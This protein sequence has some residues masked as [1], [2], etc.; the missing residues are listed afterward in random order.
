M[1]SSEQLPYFPF[2]AYDWLSSPSRAALDL[3][4]Q[5]LYVLLLALQWRLNGFS[6]DPAR[7]QVITQIN[8]RTF[9]RLWKQ[10]APLFPVDP[11]DGRRRNPRL[12]QERRKVLAS[13]SLRQKGG[14]ARAA[15]AARTRGRFDQQTHQQADQQTH[16]QA[17]ADSTSSNTSKATSSS[18]SKGTSSPPAMYR[19]EVQDQD[20]EQDPATA[21]AAAVHLP[22]ETV[23]N[24]PRRPGKVRLVPLVHIPPMVFQAFVRELRAEHQEADEASFVESVKKAC[25]EKGWHYNA[26]IISTALRR[27]EARQLRES[28]S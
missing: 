28:L 27:E 14:R 13:R 7:V 24:S 9:R 8:G 20:Q 26:G 18:T 15:N 6:H 19:S 4:A 16:Q 22:V 23:E 21:G 25:A 5:G 3:D 11:T 12:E 1:D 10:L 17:G 2:W